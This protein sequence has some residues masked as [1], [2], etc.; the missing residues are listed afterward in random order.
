MPRTSKTTPPASATHASSHLPPAHSEPCA[1]DVVDT[2]YLQTLMGYNARRA[3]FADLHYQE[4]ARPGT[5]SSSDGAMLPTGIQIGL[6]VRPTAVSVVLAQG[7]LAETGGD[8][9]LAIE[10]KG[11]IEVTLPS[12]GSAYTRD[13]V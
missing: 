12:G 8:L 1:V 5:I 10:G 9:D 6:G 13:G 3:D 2:G 11:Y 7:P 4:Y